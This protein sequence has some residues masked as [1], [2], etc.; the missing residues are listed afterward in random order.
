MKQ[1]RVQGRAV[2]V[3]L[4]VFD[5]DGLMFESLPFWKELASSQL[6]AAAEYMPQELRERWMRVMGVTC[7][8]SGGEPQ[9]VQVENPGALATAPPAE[10]TI[11]IA[12]LLAE[13]RRMDWVDARRTARA[14]VKAGDERL[15]LRR[16]LTP[17]KGFPEILK[18]LRTAGI[19][20]GIATSDTTERA[21]E[22]IRL[23]DDPDALS[24][25][26]TP[27]EVERAKPDR[28][29]LDLACKL[30]GA[31]MSNVLMIGDSLVDVKMARSAGAV[32]IGVPEDRAVAASMEGI[33]DAILDSLD[34]LTT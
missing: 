33:A 1:I 25:V 23:F 13:H 7:E 34:E 12:A 5:K 26:I 20:Y 11:L 24:F 21:Y 31:K 32:G 19:P 15:D 14:I 16:A 29:M 18:R 27:V 3:E 17:R 30:T 28:E 6:R 8:W 2:P 9:V 4:V 22:S 10:E